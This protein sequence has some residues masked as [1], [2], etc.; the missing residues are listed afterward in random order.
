[1]RLESLCRISMRYADASWQ[2]PYGSREAD[3]EALG[4]G[5]SDG[6]V[7]GEIEGELVWANYPRRR[8]DGVWTPNLQ[9][10]TKGPPNSVIRAW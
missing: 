8:Q 7:S 4:F 3:A 9:G 6:A 10:M 5:H 1:M 2:R